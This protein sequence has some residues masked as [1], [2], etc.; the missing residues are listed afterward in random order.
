MSGCGV[1]NS[2][3][4]GG[5]NAAEN[6]FPWHCA[7]LKSDDTWHPGAATLISCD[8]VII[9]TSATL[10]PC[11]NNCETEYVSLMLIILLL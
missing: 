8:P 11:T 10:F 7:I 5:Q 1:T 2:R 4:I 9:V 6:Q 3:I